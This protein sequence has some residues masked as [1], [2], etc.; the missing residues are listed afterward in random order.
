[1]YYSVN[2][3]ISS[4]L[5][6]THTHTQ[7]ANRLGNDYIRIKVTKRIFS[8]GRVIPN[9]KKNMYCLK[10]TLELRRSRHVGEI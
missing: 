7:N 9:I 5:L 8:K 3:A 10:C 6:Q 2:S 1:M 4:V